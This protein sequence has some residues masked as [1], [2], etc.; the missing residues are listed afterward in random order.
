MGYS[1]ETVESVIALLE[2]QSITSHFDADSGQALEQLKNFVKQVLKPS[3][4]AKTLNQPLALVD[5]SVEASE[6]HVYFTKHLFHPF[7]RDG[8]MRIRYAYMEA[9]AANR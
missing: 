8:R 6:N 4:V 2:A 9:V 5:I 1:Q 3:Y 7:Y